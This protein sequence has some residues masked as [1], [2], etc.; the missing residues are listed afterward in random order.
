MTRS[1]TDVPDSYFFHSKIE[2]ELLK[3]ISSL[4]IPSKHFM[5]F[6]NPYP[7]PNIPEIDLVRRTMGRMVNS[8]GL[9]SLMGR[10]PIR[11][12]TQTTGVGMQGLI[13]ILVVA[14]VSVE[15]S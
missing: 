13:A 14:L 3:R 6:P 5:P 12:W 1:A 9:F 4:D 15:S 2:E 11:S 10:C 8:R 7:H